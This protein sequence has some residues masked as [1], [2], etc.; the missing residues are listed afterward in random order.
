MDPRLEEVVFSRLAAAEAARDPDRLAFVFENGE[1]PAEPLTT[2]GLALGG[3]KLAAALAGAGLGR[4]DR[5][6]VMLR[7]HPEFLVSLAAN[8]KMALPTVPVDPRSRGAKL[9]YFLGFA[10][11]SGLITADYVVADP[12]AAEVIRASGVRTWVLSTPEGRAAGFDVSGWPSLNEVLDGPE[13]GTPGEQVESLGEPWLLA[14][15]SGT[16]GDPKAI[17]FTYER[18]SLYRGLPRFFGYQ[19]DDVTYTGLSLT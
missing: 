10:E 14:Y 6:A 7:N 2:G 8:A 18:M 12:A 16:T 5:V 13:V 9:A 11:C 19:P 1:H 17:E 3:D 15:T 4:G